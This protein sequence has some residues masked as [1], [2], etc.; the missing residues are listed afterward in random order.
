[1]EAGASPARS[2]PASVAALFKEQRRTLSR[3]LSIPSVIVTA[4]RT[5]VGTSPHDVVLREGTHT[6]PDDDIHEWHRWWQRLTRLRSHVEPHRRAIGG[7]AIA[8]GV[9]RGIACGRCRE[10]EIILGGTAGQQHHDGQ[11]SDPVPH[12]VSSHV[13]TSFTEMLPPVMTS[14]KAPPRHAGLMAA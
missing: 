2:M 8:G 9:G 12:G 13:A 10:R 6:L 5:K 7:R 4:R 11:R 3:L 1:M 14:P